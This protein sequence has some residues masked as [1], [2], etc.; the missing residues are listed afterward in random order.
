MRGSEDAAVAVL[1][2]AVTVKCAGWSSCHPG[3]AVLL[4]ACQ[5]SKHFAYQPEN[6]CMKVFV[7]VFCFLN[8]F[9]SH[10]FPD[11]SN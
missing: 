11:A 7:A 9:L 6:A 4:S 2:Q 10:L 3:S 5:T 1:Q 8:C